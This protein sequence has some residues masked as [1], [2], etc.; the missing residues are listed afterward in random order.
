MPITRGSALHY[1][2]L[3]LI[4]GNLFALFIGIWMLLSTPGWV[5]FSI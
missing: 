1:M 5:M 3:L 2:M 4:C